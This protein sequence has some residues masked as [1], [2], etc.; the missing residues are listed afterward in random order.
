MDNPVDPNTKSR[1]GMSA[2]HY[3]ALNG[4]IEC[5]KIL[6][7]HKAVIDMPGK[8]RMTPL[9]I[10]ASKGHAHAV[11]FLLENSAKINAKDKFKRNALIVAVRNGH[12]KVAS[13]LLK[14]FINDI[15][16]F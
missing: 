8:M 1:D 7:E 11:T 2:I 10:A 15:Y 6:L 9:I 16:V 14:R 3:A 13:I 5:L 12:L 4:N